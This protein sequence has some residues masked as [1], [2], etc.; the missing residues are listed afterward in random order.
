MT[1]LLVTGD[2]EWNNRPLVEEV[3]EDLRADGFEKLIGGACRGLD[4][5]AAAVWRKMGLPIQEYAVTKDRNQKMLDEEPGISLVCGF[6]D[7][8]AESRGT[9]DMLRRAQAAGKQIRFWTYA[10][11]RNCCHHGVRWY[12]PCKGCKRGWRPHD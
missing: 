3:L 2:R 8:L 9:M 5:I 6:H 11:E 1:T 10:G 4:S 7:N 12:N